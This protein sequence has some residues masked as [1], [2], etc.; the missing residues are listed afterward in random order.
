MKSHCGC[1]WENPCTDAGTCQTDERQSRLSEPGVP[2][3]RFDVIGGGAREGELISRCVLIRLSSR[4]SEGVR[5]GCRK[6]RCRGR[7][8]AISHCA[9]N[10]PTTKPTTATAAFVI[11][12]KMTTFMS[13]SSPA[14]LLGNGRDVKSRGFLKQR[15]IRY[16]ASPMAGHRKHFRAPTKRIPYILRNP[17]RFSTLKGL[18]KTAASA[19]HQL[20]QPPHNSGIDRNPPQLLVM[21]NRANR[22]SPRKRQC[23][24]A[25]LKS[26]QQPLN[27][28][29]KS[30][31]FSGR[32]L[33]CRRVVPVLEQPPIQ[34]Q[35]FNRLRQPVP[36]AIIQLI[37]PMGSRHHPYVAG[38]VLLP[39]PRRRRGQIRLIRLGHAPRNRPR[40]GLDRLIRRPDPAAHQCP[41]PKSKR[42]AARIMAFQ[43]IR[44][45][46]VQDDFVVDDAGHESLPISGTLSSHLRV[47]I[48]DTKRY[49]R[50]CR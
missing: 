36:A 21:M 35:F 39:R 14:Q 42:P 18:F 23:E 33:D 7:R 20:I 12:P 40:R 30:Q 31:C 44:R 26:F 50:R 8:R 17:P 4:N 19:G 48:G 45:Q 2:R 29:S 37:R 3:R 41:R 46:A 24:I 49:L 13:N 38:Q 6:S 32:K 10:S 15:P 43:P 34:A 16:W 28:I 9:S 25:L 1:Y 27:K 5:T 11:T 47:C 22:P